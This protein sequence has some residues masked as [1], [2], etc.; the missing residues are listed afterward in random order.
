MKKLSTVLILSLVFYFFQ[1]LYSSSLDAQTSK[2]TISDTTKKSAQKLN[3]EKDQPKL[4]LPDVLIYGTDRAVRIAGDKLDR[5]K[6]EVKL[7]APPVHYQPVT[8]DLQLENHKGYFE[9]KKK[10][11]DSRTIIHLSVGRYQQFNINAGRW[12]EAKNYN[13]S[14]WAN[15]ERSSGQYENSEYYHGAFQSQVGIRLSPKFIVSSRGHLRLIN[16]GLYGAQL[17]NLQRH[18]NG[19]DIEIAAQWSTSTEQSADFSASF[20]Q[21]EYKD[22]EAENYLSKLIERR[23]GLTTTYQAKFRRLPIFIRGWFEHQK[24]NSVAIDTASAQ[25]YFLLKSWTSFK[26]KKYFTFNP[27]ILFEILELNDSFSEYQFSPEIELI[28]TPT[29]KIGLFLKGTKGYSPLNY[30]SLIERNPFTSYQTK[31]FPTKKEMEL[32]LG[33]EYNPSARISVSGE[34][35]RQNWKNYTY[36][37]PEIGIDLF[38]LNA[39]NKVSLTILN[40]QTKFTIF[41][42]LN[43]DAG[44]QINFDK[45]KDDSLTKKGSHLP[46]LERLRLPVNLEYN[47]DK[48]AKASLAFLWIS[49]RYSDLNKNEQLSSIALLSL[50]FEKQLI[51]NISVFVEGNNL[52]NQKYEFWLNYPGMGFYFEAG[53]KG[54]W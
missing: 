18:I 13:Y 9:S 40:F 4:E 5:F 48:T 29:T 19:G 24:L 16:Y 46:Y 41:S 2:T 1:F 52:L 36:W 47:I 17:E 21:N 14:G 6:E 7:V 10:G 31:L 42:K 50:H 26:V 8:K 44:C 3:P 45:V 49:P 20:Q 35:I 23:I 12:K 15:Y 39:I 27:G 30:Y 32:K 54:S 53:L 11:I 37:L 51:K 33:I 25:N 38:Q 34:I 43:F 22:D 28:V